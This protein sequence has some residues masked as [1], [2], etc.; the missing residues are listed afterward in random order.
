MSRHTVFR[1][2]GSVARRHRLIRREFWHLPQLPLSAT[3]CPAQKLP[4]GGDSGQVGRKLRERQDGGCKRTPSNT[5]RRLQRWAAVM[6]GGRAGGGRFGAGL[7][8]GWGGE[9]GATWEGGSAAD[10]A[11]SRAASRCTF[12]AM[13][14]SCSSLQSMC[15]T[16][17][18]CTC[19]CGPP[20]RPPVLSLPR[21]FH[22]RTGR[23][24]HARLTHPTVPK[25]CCRSVVQLA[26]LPCSRKC[27]CGAQRYLH[28][29]CKITFAARQH[30]GSDRVF[31]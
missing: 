19:T 1:S 3:G 28:T 6:V 9:V 5:D 8:R 21:C 15:D 4:E 27:V 30:T 13:P 17:S 20:L 24:T 12:R 16:A 14:R 22:G 18:C 25:V 11:A 31:L 26:A 7:D 2:S 29:R 23:H 10:T